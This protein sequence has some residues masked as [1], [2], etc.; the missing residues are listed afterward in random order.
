MD[1]NVLFE[2]REIESGRRKVAVALNDL[3]LNV[4]L[5]SGISG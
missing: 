5:C 1:L 4:D 2:I 3:L